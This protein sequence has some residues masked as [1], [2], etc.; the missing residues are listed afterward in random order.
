MVLYCSIEL[1]KER[2]ISIEVVDSEGKI[3]QSAVLDG[4]TLTL[5]VKTQ[6]ARSVVTQKDASIVSTVEKGSDKSEVTQTPTDVTIKCKNF[7][8]QAEK[9]ETSSAKDTRIEASGAA[10]ISSTKDLSMQTKAK[11]KLSATSDVD[12]SSSAS[13]AMKGNLKASLS[14]TTVEATAKSK[15]RIDGG[16][17]LQLEALKVAAKG[18]AQLEAA[19]PI[20]NI[21]QALTSVKGSLVKLEAAL[22]KLG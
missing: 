15:A 20:T 2:G 19:A 3:T 16:A 14:A 9:V 21:G 17:Q 18:K 11:A 5:T 6:D 1:S 13:L 10:T 4:T 7:T 8:V 22:V 12:I